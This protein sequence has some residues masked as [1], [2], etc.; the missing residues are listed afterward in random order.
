LTAIQCWRTIGKLARLFFHTLTIEQLR[1]VPDRNAEEDPL[2]DLIS[3]T[4]SVTEACEISGFTPGW[5]RQL[6]IRGEIKGF[7]IGRDW[8]LTE[9]ALR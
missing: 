4:I 1:Q 7:K 3:R 2:A 8:R 9:A 5:I 6:L